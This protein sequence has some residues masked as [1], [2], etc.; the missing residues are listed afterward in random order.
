LFIYK[1]FSITFGFDTF[2]FDTVL[3]LDFDTF[4]NYLHVENDMYTCI[5]QWNL[6]D[7]YLVG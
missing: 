7:F 5:L 3:H 2:G 4:V 6:L 1:A